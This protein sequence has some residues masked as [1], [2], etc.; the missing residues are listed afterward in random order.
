MVMRRI[1]IIGA[2]LSG[3]TVFHELKNV[4]NVT[5]FEKSAK[6]GGRISVRVSSDFGFDHGTQFF[7]V[8]DPDFLSF[9]KPLIEL[10]VVRQWNARI[11]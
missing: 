5:I 10:G 9:L 7:T 6:V 1:A 3:L 4:A 2:G 11:A 8:K